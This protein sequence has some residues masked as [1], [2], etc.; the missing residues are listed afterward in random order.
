[1]D[2]AM[3]TSGLALLT[4]C[5]LGNVAG[6]VGSKFL[7]R[8]IPLVASGILIINSLSNLNFI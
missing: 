2:Y 8:M 3:L 7:F 1:M 4:T 5:T 6:D